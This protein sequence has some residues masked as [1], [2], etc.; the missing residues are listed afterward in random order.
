[1]SPRWHKVVR[2]LT[3]H[4]GRTALVVLSIAVGIFAVAV[5]LGGR[6]VLIREFDRSFAVS[7]PMNAQLTTSPFDDH[8]LKRVQDFRGVQFAEGRRTANMRYRI[9]KASE[10]AKLGETGIEALKHPPATQRSETQ[11]QAETVGVVAIRDFGDIKVDRFT[12]EEGSAWPPRAGEIVLERSALMTGDYKVGDLLFVEL[13]DGSRYPLKVAGF[14]HDINA[15]PAM[16]VGRV[17]GYIS[18]DTLRLLQMPESYNQLAMTFAG[19]DLTRI[20]AS[21]EAA[22]IRD[23]VLSPAGVRVLSS[24]VPAPGSHFLG[25]IFKALSILLLA[26][27]VMA[28]VLSG[29]LVVNTVSAIMAQQVKQVGIMKAVGGRINQVSAMYLTTVAIFGLMAIAIGIPAGLAAGAWFVDYAA[30]LLNFKVVS[31][32]VPMDVI[33]LLVAIGI[34]VP[35]LA[36]LVPVFRGTRAPVAQSLRASGVDSAQFG[37]GIIDRVLG[38]IRGLPRP[39]ALSLRNTFLRKGRLVLTLTTLILASAV[40]MSVMSS[41]ASMIETVHEADVAWNYDARLDFAQ[42]VNGTAAVRA[43][44]KTL[45]VTEVQAVAIAYPSL[46]REDGSENQRLILAGVDPESDFTSQKLSAGRWLQKGDTDQVVINSD[47]IRDEP[48]LKVGDTMRLKVLDKTREYKIVGIVSGQLMGPVIYQT[49]GAMD[50]SLAL[51]GAVGRIYVR[52]RAHD[53]ETQGRM[54]LRIESRLKDAGYEVG[55]SITK[56][57]LLDNVGSQ[58]GILTTFLVIMAVLLAIVGVIG[59]TGTMSINVLESTREI[60]VMRAT[61]AGHSDIYRIF[62]T[63]GVVIG[64]IAWAVG[65]MIAYPMSLWLTNLLGNAI[66]TPLASV[67]SW[68]G[69]FVWLAIVI[70]VSALASVLPARRASQ[71]SVR[72]AIAYE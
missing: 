5:V 63:E 41:R 8:V 46:Q 22:A 10:V 24:Y 66:S 30:G 70:A 54:A 32:E 69:V 14:A 53:A 20:A 44:A 61:G 9:V 43:V 49:A 27:G 48:D 58:F 19:H 60:G 45:G 50:K 59:L 39:V 36:A 6:A 40:V 25:D 56:S 34:L 18:F 42:P 62:I 11:G 37:H 13:P 16:F 7:N 2:D 67:F 47:V 55:N 21:R 51:D 68:E 1:M 57:E 15:L 29:F 52:T 35:V 28:L 72:D 33:A 71:V 26:M 38:L 65:A 23:D 64:V 4:P 12:P 3:S 17:T 31:Y